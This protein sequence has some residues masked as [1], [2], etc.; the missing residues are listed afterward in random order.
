MSFAKEYIEKKESADHYIELLAT[1][2]SEFPEPLASAVRYSL[3]SGGK[4]LRPILFLVGYGLFGGEPSE[5]SI[6]ILQAIECIHTYSLIHDDLPCMDDDDYR[7]GKLTSHKVYGEA[8]ALLAGDALLNLAYQLMFAA[9]KLT[10]DT[11]RTLRACTAVANAA[12]GTGMI[13]GQ[14]LDLVPEDSH[15]GRRLTYIYQHKTADLISA[16]LMAGALMGGA[17]ERQV[18]ALGKYGDNFGLCF[19]LTDDILDA[20]EKGDKN[21]STYIKL[22]GLAN[23]KITLSDRIS[24]AV[25]GLNALDVDTDFLRA[26]ALKVADRKE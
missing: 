24:A 17:D 18:E 22:Y 5:A 21:K 4:R 7:R 2:V 11:D 16:S 1:E 25:Q 12:S 10:D 13:G 19:Q 20:E 26:L 23:A 8:N 9:L 3:F 14:T 15:A 6:K